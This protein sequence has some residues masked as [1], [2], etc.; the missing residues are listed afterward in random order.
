MRKNLVTRSM[1]L[2][3]LSLV[4]LP[5]SSGHSLNDYS[6]NNMETFFVFTYDNEDWSSAVQWE[7]PG[8]QYELTAL[9]ISST[10]FLKNIHATWIHNDSKLYLSHCDGFNWTV[11]QTFIELDPYSSLD[12]AVISDEKGSDHLWW[13]GE[14]YTVT[15]NNFND[16]NWSEN[17]TLDVPVTSI[18][19]SHL[20]TGGVMYLMDSTTLW[21]GNG[22]STPITINKGFDYYLKKVTVIDSDLMHLFFTTRSHED[23]FNVLSIQSLD[24]GQRWTNQVT[25]INA[26][27]MSLIPYYHILSTDFTHPIV[28][29]DE[30]NDLYLFHKVDRTWESDSF[31]EEAIFEH[32]VFYSYFNGTFWTPQ[33]SLSLPEKLLSVNIEDAIVGPDDNV[34]LFWIARF[35]GT[36][37]W[38]LEHDIIAKNGT[39]LKRNRVMS[40]L[41]HLSN[42]HSVVSDLGVLQVLVV[43]TIVQSNT[44]DTTIPGL[45][46]GL[47]LSSGFVA[48]FLSNKKRKN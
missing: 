22:S 43:D 7:E 32:M 34:H 29:R 27:P 5:I 30:D 15:Y 31:S 10:D 21:I 44:S 41:N 39:L 4:I 45:E 33:I 2:A 9:K 12:Y 37:L 36:H 3:F 17:I 13:M 18:H 11:T 24:G 48:L 1:I 25:V 14:N 19:D 20:S 46:F 40:S 47:A 16:S 6:T 28:A 35:E 23:N 26:S 42:I 8:S 38:E